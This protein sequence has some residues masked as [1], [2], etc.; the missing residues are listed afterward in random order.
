MAKLSLMAEYILFGEMMTSCPCLPV[1]Y[2]KDKVCVS[3]YCQF[4]SWHQ[5]LTYITVLSHTEICS[6]YLLYV[7]YAVK[8]KVAAHWF[9][10][11]HLKQIWPVI[12]TLRECEISSFDSGSRLISSFSS[13]TPVDQMLPKAP[14]TE[15]ENISYGTTGP[16]DL[17]VI[18]FVKTSV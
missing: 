8:S 4:N 18:F 3:H 16:F 13:S 11:L 17:Q 15:R 2:R 7:L 12:F 10:L 5:K 14:A 9:S 1:S 6:M